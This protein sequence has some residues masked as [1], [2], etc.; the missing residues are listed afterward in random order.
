MPGPGKRKATDTDFP[1]DR[2]YGRGSPDSR[3][4]VPNPVSPRLPGFV[5]RDAR[6]RQ[7]RSANRDA[8]EQAVLDSS[9]ILL[10]DLDALTVALDRPGTDLNAI[11]SVLADDL[12]LAVPS[13]LGLTLTLYVDGLPVTMTARAGSPTGAARDVLALPLGPLTA[14]EPDS[15]LVLYA[16]T[17]GAFT[18][19]Q[20]DMAFYRIVAAT[21][22]APS[23]VVSPIA[24][25]PGPAGI[26]GLVELG[27]INQAIGVLLDRGR[28]VESA[29]DELH[30][31]A[32][33]QGRSLFRVAEELLDAITAEPRDDPPG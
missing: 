17:P 18:E 5:P 22:P 6:A 7:R 28:T 10:E 8:S 3:R 12:I 26:T 31:A 19:L 14:F 15:S 2:E 1:G 4:Q 25:W 29:R 33:E 13:F 27:V 24:G 21:A 23:L 11:L 20:T 16:A 9:R 30:R 32:R